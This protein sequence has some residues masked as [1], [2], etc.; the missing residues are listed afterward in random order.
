M[1]KLIIAPSKIHGRGVFTKV[2][3]PNGTR[4]FVVAD[5]KEYENGGNIMTVF[6][7]LVNHKWDSNCEFKEGDNGLV[8]LNSIKN[9]YPKEELTIDYSILPFPFKSD[10]TGYKQ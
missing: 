3:I 5:L 2:K 4:M 8:Y 9:I 7:K 6:G 10:V 1:N